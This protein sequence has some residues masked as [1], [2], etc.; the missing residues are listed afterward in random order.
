MKI[1]IGQTELEVLNCYAFR[2]GNGKLVLNLELL[3]EVMDATSLY[4]LI[5][6]NTEDIVCT[7]D[8]GTQKIF[9]GFR[10]STNLT[11]TSKTDDTGVIMQIYKAEVECV[12]EQEFQNGI[13]KQQIAEL[14]QSI[15]QQT[16]VIN[17]QAET[18]H[19]Q[20]Q[21]INN[22]AMSI[23]LMEDVMLEQL[24]AEDI[25][26]DDDTAEETIVTKETLVMEESEVA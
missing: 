19:A 4:N 23:T 14:N 26:T 20:T 3:Q 9:S 24:M 5:K 13:L 2:H 11:M 10:Y 12:S 25:M 15:A 1:L 16:E 7:Y 18:I 17:T 8:D 6:N 22:Q 21:A